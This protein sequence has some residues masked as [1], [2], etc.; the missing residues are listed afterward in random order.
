MEKCSAELQRYEK[1]VILTNPNL[2]TGVSL[3]EFLDI[4]IN[5]DMTT[6]LIILIMYIK[7]IMLI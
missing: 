1:V 3:D 4:F 6:L 7:A 5:M 2:A